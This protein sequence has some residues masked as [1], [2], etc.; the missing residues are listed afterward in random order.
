[1]VKPLREEILDNDLTQVYIAATIGR[2]HG[3]SNIYSLSL[4]QDL[5]SRLRPHAIFNDG[6]WYTSAPPYAWLLYPF[7]FFNPVAVVYLWLGLSMLALI[8]TWW[9]AAPGSGRMRWLWLLGALTWYPV[10]YGLSLV[11]PVLILTFVV[12]LGWRL[13]DSG[14]QYL[15]GAV[16]G[17]TVIKPQLIILLPLVLLITGRWRVALP[18]AAIG[19]LFGLLSLLALGGDGLGDYRVTLAHQSQLANNRYFTLA[20]LLGPGVIGVAGSALVVVI[21]S[22]GAYLNRHASVARLFA[23]GLVASMLGATY[24]H[25]QDFT[26]LVLAAWLF[27][28]DNR[29]A[30]QRWWLLVVVVGGELAWPLTPLPVLIGVGVWLAILIAPRRTTSTVAA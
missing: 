4:Q 17:L 2:D 29:P 13:A 10:L 25:L 26:I 23:L 24:W 3:W 30:W 9:L 11:Q 28:R 22:I 1:M 21:V 18:M 16:L 15:A 14:R 6:A 27:W 7:T 5:F 12:A 20:Y 19:L 8:G